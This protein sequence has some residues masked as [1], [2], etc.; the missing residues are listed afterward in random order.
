MLNNFSQAENNDSKEQLAD[1]LSDNKHN[2]GT[3][4]V[5]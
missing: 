1:I 3:C 2:P 5:L 4:E